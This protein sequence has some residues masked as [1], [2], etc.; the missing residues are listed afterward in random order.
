MAFTTVLIEEG[1]RNYVIQVAGDPVDAAAV[2]VN[3]SALNP[4]CQA[5]RL[6]RVSYDCG[7]GV[8]VELSFDGAAGEFLSLSEGSGQ[9]ICYK[10]VG[11]IPNRVGGTG[12]VL[13][14]SS[15]T[16]PAGY[17]MTLHFAKQNPLIPR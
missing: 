12:N 16:A 4:P 10:S 9:T 3:A 15:G 1:H 11:G 17:S 13:M 8:E 5:V 7:P 6:M 2:L 14:T